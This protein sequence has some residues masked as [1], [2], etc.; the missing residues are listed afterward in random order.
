V[1]KLKALG[2]KHAYIDGGKTIQTFLAESCIA[3]M[4]ITTIPILLGD[5]IRLFGKVN[6]DI[7]LKHIETKT[8]ANGFVQIRYAPSQVA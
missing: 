3:E 4:T 1:E 6:G 7:K 5:G 8:Y 2:C